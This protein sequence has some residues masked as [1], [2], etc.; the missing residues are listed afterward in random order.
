M[1]NNPVGKYLGK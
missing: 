1:S